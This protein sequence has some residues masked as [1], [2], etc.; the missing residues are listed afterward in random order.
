MN[1]HIQTKRTLLDLAIKAHILESIDNSGYDGGILEDDKAKLTF[2]Y[3]TFISEYGWAIKHH[4]EVGAFKE[5][6]QGLP[7]AMTVHFTNHDILQFAL[8][9]GYYG[10]SMTERQENQ[11]LDNWFNLVAVKTFQLFRKHKVGA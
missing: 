3:N 11:V 4:G 9:T 8:S 10:E 7:S 1:T 5:W 6:L 2:L